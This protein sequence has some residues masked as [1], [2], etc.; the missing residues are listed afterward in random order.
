MYEG[1]VVNG[2]VV[3]RDMLSSRSILQGIKE[4]PPKETKSKGK[5]KKG[6]GKKKGSDESGSGD[7]TEDLPVGPQPFLPLRFV[8]VFCVYRVSAVGVK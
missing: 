6:K 4:E 8:S 5:G 1:L 3:D 7:D 2:V